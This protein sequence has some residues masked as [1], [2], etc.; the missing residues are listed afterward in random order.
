MRSQ[1]DELFS[2][3]EAL[4][5]AVLI[6]VSDDYEN[7]ALITESLNAI[8]EPGFNSEEIVHP[9]LASF[10][11]T[12][13]ERNL[14]TSDIVEALRR[15]HTKGLIAAYKLS[16]LPPYATEIPLAGPLESLWFYVT[17]SGKLV[18]SKLE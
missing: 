15:L 10:A 1:E 16:P 12:F 17:Q 7:I 6:A 14:T 9:L 13:R 2:D 8:K 4:D 5:A 18:N 3:L 11:N